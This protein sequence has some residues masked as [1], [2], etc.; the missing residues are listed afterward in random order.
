MWMNGKIALRMVMSKAI[1]KKNKKKGMP[2]VRGAA[3]YSLP[4]SAKE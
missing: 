2:P 4:S 1:K 3:R